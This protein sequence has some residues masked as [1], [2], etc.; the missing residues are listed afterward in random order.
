[1]LKD[2]KIIKKLYGEQMMHF[3]RSAFST[4]LEKEGLLP[5]LDYL[6]FYFMY[7]HYN[8]WT[9]IEEISKQKRK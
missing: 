6:G 7:R 3:C 5:N 2:L 4:I 9:I 1:M 8:R